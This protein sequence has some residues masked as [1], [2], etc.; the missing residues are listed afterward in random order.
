MT[1][2]PSPGP[3]FARLRVLFQPPWRTRLLRGLLICMGLG[4]VVLLGTTLWVLPQLPDITA[5]THY[6]PKQ[7][8][9]VF[10]ADGVQIGGFGSER[11][12]YQRFDQIPQRMKDALLAVEDARFYE[13]SGIDPISVARAAVSVASFG[14]VRRVQGGSTITQQVARTFLLTRER[15]LTRKLKEAILSLRI[16]AALS[17]DQILELYMNQIYLGSRAYGFE[18]AAQTYFGKTLSALSPAECAMLAG[19]PQN[20]HYVN[21]IRNPERA[22]ARQLVAL[23]LMHA[24]GAI[25]DAEYQAAK[26]EKLVVRKAVVSEVHAEYV[27]EMVRQQVVA[28]YGDKA[29]TQ[30]IDVTTTLV[31]AEQQAAHQ[32]LRKTLIEHTLRQPW[33]G[34]EDFETLAAELHDDDPAVAQV[35]AGT[36]DDDDLRAAIVTQASPTAVTAVLAS[37]EVIHIDKAGLRQAQPGLAPKTSSKL[38]VHRGAIVRVLLQGKTWTL[39]QWPEAEGALVAVQPTSG[40]V[41]ALVG[42]FDFGHNQFNHAT[43]GWRQPGSSFKPFIYA[44]ALDHG[45]MP[46]TIVNDAPITMGDWS[47]SNSDGSLDGPITLK[48]ALARSKNLVTIRLVQLLGAGPMRDWTMRFG[49]DRERHPDNLTLALGTGATTPLQLASAYGVLANGGYLLPPVLVRKISTTQGEVLFEAPLTAPDEAQR[50]TS[51]RNAFLTSTLLQEVTRSGTAARAQAALKR[52]DLYGKTGTTNEVVD[53][54]FAGFQPERAAVVWIGYDSPRSLGGHQS[55]ASLALPAWIDYM[56]TALKG[57]PVRELTPPEG[58][59]R[60]DGNWR[61]SEWALGGAIPSLGLDGQVIGPA[62]I[63]QVP[64]TAGAPGPDGAAVSVP[65]TPG[66]PSGSAAEPA[67]PAPTPGN[68]FRHL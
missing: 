17:K 56:A 7:P 23:S 19:L 49:F 46:D 38:A 50:A 5:L 43:Q 57:V 28:Q 42:G 13:H 29:Y 8:L 37:G 27:A 3:L 31:A 21:P 67:P 4:A 15:T 48:E 55:G 18:A 63:P 60:I 14:L 40:E 68:P 34:P 36:D 22:R 66:T 64:A 20:P 62:L 52:P 25:N 16:E 11:R 61:Y 39:T 6:E 1:T 33:H 53:A 54:W 30:G 45:V 12:V 2:L 65:V 47:P 10:T 51:E 35:L 32:A 24:H 41:R 58:V 9:R 59:L 26:T 44:G